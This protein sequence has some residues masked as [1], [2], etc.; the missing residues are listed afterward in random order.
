MEHLTRQPIQSNLT[1]SFLRA[2]DSPFFKL[3][4]LKELESDISKELMS[5][6]ET[7]DNDSPLYNL[8]ER[9]RDQEEQSEELENYCSFNKFNGSKL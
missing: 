2:E 5:S 6:K 1:V 7:V 8:N 9:S 3:L 4:R